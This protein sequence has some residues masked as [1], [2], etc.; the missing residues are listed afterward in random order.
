VSLQVRG[1]TRG[2]AKPKATSSEEFAGDQAKM[3]G[4]SDA[5][6]NIKECLKFKNS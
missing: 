5:S 6:D 3:S 4:F 2:P 1:N